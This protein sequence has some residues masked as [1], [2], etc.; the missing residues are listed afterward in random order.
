[1]AL[2]PCYFIQ[3]KECVSC[4]QHLHRNVGGRR[5]GGC[6]SDCMGC[7]CWSIASGFQSTSLTTSELSFLSGGC[8]GRCTYTNLQNKVV[9]I[10]RFSMQL[11]V[12]FFHRKIWTYTY[13]TS[14][15]ILLG[16]EHDQAFASHLDLNVTV[17]TVAAAGSAICIQGYVSYAEWNMPYQVLLCALSMAKAGPQ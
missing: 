16:T 8:N 12:F 9:Q 17:V 10:K 13:P 5:Q 4:I 14:T 2:S 6:T 7:T 1:M 11:L 3:H 15:V